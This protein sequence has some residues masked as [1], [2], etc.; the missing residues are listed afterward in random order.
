MTN[1]FLVSYFLLW[2]TVIFLGVALFI[3]YSHVGQTL[4]G[5]REGLALQGPDLNKRLE[6]RVL[7]TIAGPQYTLGTPS[8]EPR[9]VV[10]VSPQCVSCGRLLKALPELMQ[11]FD[12]R[13]ETLLVCRG[14]SPEV[15]AFTSDVPKEVLVYA[16]TRGDLVKAYG[17]LVTPFALAI[18]AEGFVRH[19]GVPNVDANGLS[20]FVNRV[21]QSEH[22]RQELLRT[23][24]PAVAR[25]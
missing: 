23:A 13:L 1:I 25:A 8:S 10:F 9:L 19:K 20:A 4:F 14:T 16:D 21:L 12:A 2:G 15:S 17:I 11:R 22:R 7:N 5:S 3:L 18:D 6:P 24:V